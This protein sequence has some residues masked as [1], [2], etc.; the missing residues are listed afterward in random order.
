MSVK[1][2]Q[3]YTRISR[4]ARFNAEKGRRETW[5]EQVSRV[6]NMHKEKYADKMDLIQEEFDIA[7]NALKKK[8][9]LGSQRALQFG[10][11][12]IL[13]KEARLYNCLS[14]DTEFITDAGVK[15]F[16]DFTSGES[17]SVLTHT[18]S[19]KEAVV[20]NYGKDR[21][22]KITLKKGKSKEKTLYATS[23]HTWILKD[24]TRT[25][26]LAE[27]D[28]L[29][30]Q[31]SIFKDFVW[32]E[33]SV[34]ERMY[35]CYGLVYG[36][37]TK[38][39]D[40]EGNHKYSMIRL[41][42]HD[43]KYADRFEQM[44]FK[45]GTNNSLNG[46]FYAYTGTYLKT[47]PNLET[48]SPELVRAF[49]RGFLDADG[50][51]NRNGEKGSV[52]VSIQQSDKEA[53]DFIRKAFPVAGIY[54]SSEKEI[55]RETN[56][57]THDAIRFL[58]SDSMEGSSPIWKVISI[59][60]N[61]KEEDVWCLEVED[62]HSFVLPNGIV[63]GNCTVSYADRPRFFQEAM[64][65]LLCGCGVGFSAQTHHVKKLPTVKLPDEDAEQ[66][67]YTIPDTIEGWSD[68]IGVLL[69]SVFKTKQTFPEYF[70]KKVEFDFNE[71][72]PEGSLIKDTNGKAPGPE[73]LKKAIIK[74]SEVIKRASDIS[75]KTDG[76]RLRALDVYDIVMHSSDAVLA[77]GVRRSATICIFSPDDEEMATAKTGSWFIDNPQ[78]GRSNNSALLL[79][80]ETTKEQFDKLMKSVQDF[81]EPGFVW[82]DS[83]E[84]LYNPCVEIGMRAY[85]S[86]GNSGWSFCNLCEI[87]VKKAKNE[88]EFYEMCEAAALLGS[89]QAGYST[90]DYLGPVTEEIVRREALLG[91]SM[92]GMMD[93]PDIAFDPEIQRKGAEIIKKVNEKFVK[94]LGINPAAR[95]TC[96]KPAGSTSS[97]LGTASGIHP[98]HAKRYFRR[99]QANKLEEPLAFFRQHNPSAVR[100]SVWS[101]NNSDDVITF[102]CEVPKS[103]RTKVDVDAITLLDFV[104][105]TQQNWVEAGTNKKYC[106]EPWLRHNVSNTINVRPDEWDSVGDYIYENRKFF[107]GISLLPMSGDKDYAQAPFQTVYTPSELVEMYGDAS[108]FASGLVVRALRAFDDNLYAACDTALGYGENIEETMAKLVSEGIKD[109]EE[110]ERQA[111][112]QV[113]KSKW[114]EQITKFAKNYFDGDIRKATYCLKDVDA[115]KTWVDLE[116]EYKTVPWDDFYEETDNTK[117]SETVACAGGACEIDWTK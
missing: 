1:E 8:L 78:R 30:R 4:Y 98:H 90:F 105:S 9:V 76:F 97:I 24:G 47:T 43:K 74:I 31:P 34:E 3:E 67:V 59:E 27:G 86:K 49:V 58:I 82:A 109:L 101:A 19:W 63:T 66:V 102:L 88:E 84:A 89:L 65:L 38:V 17:V 54:I 12:A 62:D 116:R 83:T 37:G 53:Q 20:K 7:H 41:C 10:G 14:E 93:N 42:G 13:K 5:N 45:T 117:V 36:D 55:K 87:N 51:R 29:Y 103:A 111:A 81:G 72:R 114:V 70:G 71:I 28:Q 35:W 108:V 100:E 99:V 94:K 11:P 46:D 73:P 115:W 40:Q 92:T 50:E 56:L 57:G 25:E 79:R 69:S 64:Y 22:N 113:Q 77:G 48:D 16:K 18:G 112:K 60:E 75:G 110:I 23:D 106:V 61:A 39:K 91:C 107:A 52:Y 95:T 44:G 80:N 68:A 26:S 85:D 96:V 6:M 21:L 32:E 2:L 15:S 33:A 104:K